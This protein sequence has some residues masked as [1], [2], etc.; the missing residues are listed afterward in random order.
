[1]GFLNVELQLGKSYVERYSWILLIAKA[2]TC[3]K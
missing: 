1:M 3:I 2:S